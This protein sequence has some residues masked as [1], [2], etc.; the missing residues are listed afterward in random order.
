M[1][2]SSKLTS[3]LKKIK[4]PISISNNPIDYTSK[5]VSLGSCF[6]ENIGSH[7][8]NKLLTKNQSQARLWE[9]VSQADGWQTLSRRTGTGKVWTVF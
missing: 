6:A 5:I 2:F 1:L 3:E 7:L 8:I 9:H 4:S